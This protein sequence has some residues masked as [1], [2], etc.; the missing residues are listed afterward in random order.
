MNVDTTKTADAETTEVV[1]SKTDAA[2]RSISLPVTT[3]AWAAATTALTILAVTLAGFLFAARGDLAERD[4]VAA[5]NRHAEQIATDYAV[6]AATVNYAEFASWVGR[7]KQNTA[8]ALANKFDATAPKLQELLTPLKW[9]STGSPITAKI[10]SERDGVYRVTVFVTVSSTNAQNPA[11]AQTTVTYNI[12][13]DRGSDW[14]ITDVGG[15]DGTLPV[16]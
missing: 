11:G 15:L 10:L 4:R 2:P 8:P 1:A 3:V 16:K 7:L 5:D 12:T 13:V 14:K 6:G 9:A